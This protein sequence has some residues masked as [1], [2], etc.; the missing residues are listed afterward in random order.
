MPL[1]ALLL[2]AC[3]G[4]APTSLAD[5]E[6]M[7]PGPQADECWAKFLPELFR[8]DPQRAS[9]QVEKQVQD[10]RVRDFIWLTVTR[11]VDP[12]SYKYCEKIEESPLAERCRVLVSR[13]HL[14]REL[15]KERGGGGQPPNGPGG[16]PPP[17]SP[18]GGTPSGR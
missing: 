7:K 15:S 3:S 8:T 16:S 10:Q 17:G 9:E 2:W 1:L 5:C 11:E 13:P 14:H 6:T 12:G 4:S 18:P